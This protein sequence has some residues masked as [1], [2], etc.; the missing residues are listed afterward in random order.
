MM[1]GYNRDR[2]ANVRDGYVSRFRPNH[3]VTSDIKA[4]E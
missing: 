4:I 1:G 3:G 2:K